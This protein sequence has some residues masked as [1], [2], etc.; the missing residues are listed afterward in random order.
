MTACEWLTLPLSGRH[1]ACGG[2]AESWWW[3]VHSRGLLAGPL[4][5][6]KQL[7]KFISCFLNI[8][9]NLGKQARSKRFPRV[10]WYHSSPSIRMP[11]KVVASLYT[12]HVKVKLPECQYKRFTCDYGIF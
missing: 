2:V 3:P 7:F 11:K 1:G 12:L 9:E 8:A 10:N 6:R 5:S 4:R